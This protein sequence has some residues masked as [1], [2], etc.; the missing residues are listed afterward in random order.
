MYT[1]LLQFPQN[2]DKFQNLILFT[3]EEI[4]AKKFTI[5]PKLHRL[6]LNSDQFF[7]KKHNFFIYLRQ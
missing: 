7:K 3:C 4:E 5:H 6:D 2:L 1:N